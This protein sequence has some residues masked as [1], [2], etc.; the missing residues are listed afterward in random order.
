[1]PARPAWLQATH[2]SSHAL[3]QHTP[4]TQKPDAQALALVQVIPFLVLH[5]PVP[6][7]AWPSAQLPGTSVPGSARVQVPSCPAAAQD[8]QGPAQDAVEQQTP[9]TQK[10]EPQVDALAAVHPSPLARLVTLYSQVSLVGP[11]PP[12]KNTTT[13]R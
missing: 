6:S 8:W 11:E 4:S 10:P 5:L 7:Q 12:P 9:S 2:M 3:S 1:M 13:P